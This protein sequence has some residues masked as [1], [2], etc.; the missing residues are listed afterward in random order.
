M[1]WV[2]NSEQQKLKPHELEHL[3]RGIKRM[4]KLILVVYYNLKEKN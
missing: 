2:T 3:L 1:M 4:G